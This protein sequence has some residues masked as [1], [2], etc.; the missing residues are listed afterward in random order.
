MRGAEA[1]RA[2]ASATQDGGGVPEVW[3]LVARAQQGDSAAF[4]EFYDRYVDPVYRYLYFRVGDRGLAEDF[5]SETF[6]RALRRLDSLSFRGRDPGAWLM[7]IARN[8]VLDN[9]KSSR[10]R[11][12]VVTDLQSDRHVMDERQVVEGPEHEVVGRLDGQRLLRHLHDLGADQR[13]CLVLRFLHDLSVSETAEVMGRNDGAVKAL[14][15]RALR[16]LAGML[17]Q[18]TA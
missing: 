11:L 7:T 1:P 16:R 5:T 9:V 14:Q 8:I 12:E 17:R 18:E 10:H 2:D 6:L 15:H 3:A 13:E 4:G